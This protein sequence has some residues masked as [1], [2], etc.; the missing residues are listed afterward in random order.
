MDIGYWIMNIGYWIL[1]SGCFLVWLV[2]VVV[3]SYLSCC[4]DGVGSF[5]LSL[6]SPSS[7][8]FLVAVSAVLCFCRAVLVV[9]ACVI[10]SLLA[11]T[12][13]GALW[14]PQCVAILLNTPFRRVRT[15]ILR[16]EHLPKRSPLRRTSKVCVQGRCSEHVQR[17]ELVKFG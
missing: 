12:R 14:H 3:R 8:L 17:S 7:S 2:V 10:R 1:D 13:C 9:I 5:L 6:S 16:R 15:T 11:S 4:G